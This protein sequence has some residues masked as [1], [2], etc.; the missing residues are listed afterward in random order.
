MSEVL[1]MLYDV[2]YIV[3]ILFAV[4]IVFSERKNPAVTWA[5]LMVALIVPYFG[6]IIYLCLGFDGRK[7][8]V[9]LQKSKE[10]DL[11][12]QAYLNMDINS[13]GFLNRQIDVIKRKNILNIAGAEHFDDMVYLNFVS[14]HGAYS[15][16]NE[17][18]VFHEGES[19]FDALIRDI[20]NAKVFIHLQ[21][22]IVRYDGLS[23]R[24]V[25]ALAKK[26]AEGVEVKFFI[27]GMGCA[28]TP[29]RLF[30]PL[31][32]A[33][34]RLAVFLPPY[35][36][37]LNFRNHRKLAVI[38]GKIGYIGGLNI[39]D[40]YLGK[41]KR[42]G[43]WRD[44]HIRVDGECAHQMELRFMMDW[45]FA[46]K[47]NAGKIPLD[48]RYFPATPPKRAPVGMQVVSSGPDT[49]WPSIQYGYSKMIGEANK[50]VYIQ[51]PYFVPDDSV[52]EAIRVAAL[53][54]IDVR[55]IIP[56][57][58][59]HMFVY[60]AGLS[61]L[62]ELLNAGVKCYKYEKGFLHSKLIVVD[63]LISSVGT[64][65]MDVR[66]FKLNFEVN[67][68]IYDQGAAAEVEAHF[69]LDLEDCTE[70]DAEWYNRR[71]AWTK[72]KESISRLLSPVL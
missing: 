35:F 11:L 25:A 39:G 46:V 45:N 23:R 6:F 59:D 17:L 7:H 1:T 69:L 61:Y 27:D 65:N 37:R 31:T 57:K 67:A 58:P 16:N 56:A 53:S 47:D 26:A 21:Y 28:G 8:R 48:S 41:A 33:G 10:D 19:K 5:W 64:A 13:L 52:L 54:G 72:I 40:E 42:F 30:K 24:L 44:C 43:Y 15:D 32:D 36:V 4:V 70:I 22:Y 66:S 38:D 71:S 60:W 63:S 68:F 12:Y 29:K 51:T 18:T 9:F 62:G 14:G 50:S 2:L 49:R 34:G 20:E 3:N 55:I